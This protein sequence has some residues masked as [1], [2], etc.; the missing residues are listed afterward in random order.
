M[1]MMLNKIILHVVNQDWISLFSLF[2]YLQLFYASRELVMD[3]VF[4]C[5]LVL[6]NDFEE[7][8]IIRLC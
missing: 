4:L 7:F 1:P 3:Y 2:S 6:Y 5:I 8:V